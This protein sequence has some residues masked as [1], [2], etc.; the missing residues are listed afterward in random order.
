MPLVLDSKASLI[1]VEDMGECYSE[2]TYNFKIR[3][4]VSIH[5]ADIVDYFV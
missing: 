5:I 1:V 2:K 4:G 3:S